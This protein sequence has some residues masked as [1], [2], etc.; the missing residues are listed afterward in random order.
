MQ[1]PRT[2][3]LLMAL[4]TVSGCTGSI[5]PPLS[6]GDDQCVAKESPDATANAARHSP[7]LNY[8]EARVRDTAAVNIDCSAAQIFVSRDY[9]PK[10]IGLGGEYE[11][12]RAEGCGT[13]QVYRV[14]GDH[15]VEPEGVDMFLVSHMPPRTVRLI[16]V[17]GYFARPLT[18]SDNLVIVDRRGVICRT[19]VSSTVRKNIWETSGCNLDPSTPV[20]GL[21]AIRAEDATKGARVELHWIGEAD[22]GTMSQIPP[23]MYK[24]YTLV[25]LT[26]D[27]QLE[28]AVYCRG[29]SNAEHEC[30]RFMIYR[31]RDNDVGTFL[32]VQRARWPP[33]AN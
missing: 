19:V 22:N 11:Y 13:Y 16:G 23:S 24:P 1:F 3:V 9:G 14:S 21:V 29:E 15:R 10:N 6:N 12:Y 8:V 7:P 30:E 2:C 28:V 32:P 18:I 26:G 31:G 20:L 25:T 17:P 5:T 33:V 27:K 4:A